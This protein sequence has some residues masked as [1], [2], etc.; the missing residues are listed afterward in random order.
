MAKLAELKLELIE[1][2]TYPLYLAP[3]DYLL[4]KEIKYHLRGLRCESHESLIASIEANFGYRNRMF[5]QEGIKSLEHQWTK[6]IAHEEG[7]VE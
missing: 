6:C 1:R 3:G 5:Y 7:Y 2:P 4:F